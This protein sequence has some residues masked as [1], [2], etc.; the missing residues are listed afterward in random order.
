M[1]GALWS[2]WRSLHGPLPP[3]FPGEVEYSSKTIEER[4]DARRATCEPTERS[5]LDEIEH[6]PRERGPLIVYADWLETHGRP[7]EAGAVR[8]RQ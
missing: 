3:D 5:L 4:I 1:G 6:Q 8:L 2:R 7:Q